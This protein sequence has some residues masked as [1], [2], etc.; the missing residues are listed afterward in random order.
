MSKNPKDW[1]AIPP[2]PKPPL[3]INPAEFLALSTLV[4]AILAVMAHQIERSPAGG[5]QVLINNLSAVCQDAILN[6]DIDVGS[7]DADDLRREAMEQ[8]NKILKSIKL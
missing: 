3:T 4:R 5:G 2:P 7:H 6:A 1:N 8:V